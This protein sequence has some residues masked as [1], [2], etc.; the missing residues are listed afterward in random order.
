MKGLKKRKV[1]RNTKER[2]KTNE[3]YAKG[4]R[5]QDLK[6]R[7]CW[8]WV[9]GVDIQAL[10][11]TCGECVQHEIPYE[12]PAPKSTK[13]RGWHLLSE[14]VDKDKKVYHKGV[15]MPDLFGTKRPTKMK[16]VKKD[17]DAPKQKRRTKKQIETEL[18]E[19]ELKKLTVNGKQKRKYTKRKRYL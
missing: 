3:L 11:V 5:S 6:C 8:K 18:L 10:S 19:A 2:Q 15:E 4:E 13:P 17:D 16:K 14:F 1:L 12:P 7:K 9:Y